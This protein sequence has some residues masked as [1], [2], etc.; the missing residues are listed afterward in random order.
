MVNLFLI[1]KLVIPGSSVGRASRLGGKVVGL[2]PSKSPL[3]TIKV[4]NY[5][6][7]I[8]WCKF[9]SKCPGSSVGRASRPG[10]KVASSSPI[11]LNIVDLNYW[12][13]ASRCNFNEC[14]G[15]SVGRGRRFESFKSLLR[16]WKSWII[17]MKQA[18]VN[19][20]NAQVAQRVEHPRLGGK[21]VGS[22]PIK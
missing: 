10:G 11:K 9:F 12:H 8:G 16:L 7:K 19:L 2:S 20:V 15:S 18:D 13:E 5:W 14:P 21:V 3:K 6:H 22:S 17:N 4:V 1:M